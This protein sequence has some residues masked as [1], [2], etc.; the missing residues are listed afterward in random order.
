MNLSSNQPT[1]VTRKTKLLAKKSGFGFNSNV[2]KRAT[3]S[4]PARTA[5]RFPWI[6]LILLAASIYIFWVAP[7]QPGYTDIKFSKG[8]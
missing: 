6:A 1:F 8:K 3:E 7:Y 2:P 4:S 5:T